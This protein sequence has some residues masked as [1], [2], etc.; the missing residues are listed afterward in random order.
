[1]SATRILILLL[2]ST[3]TGCSVIEKHVHL[4]PDKSTK[5]WQQSKNK[6]YRFKFSWKTI[7]YP[8]SRQVYHSCD[9]TSS[10]GIYFLQCPK[11][12]AIGPP[13]LPI[14]PRLRKKEVNG[15]AYEEL[16]V[17]LVIHTQVSLSIDTLLKGISFFFDDSATPTLPNELTIYDDRPPKYT[18]K[19]GY[20]CA[21]SNTN[22]TYIADLK[23]K[24]KPYELQ[25]VEIAFDSTFNA[26][27]NGEY[28]NLELNKKVR[29]RYYPIGYWPFE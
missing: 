18:K 10:V 9:S 3:C 20:F 17:R 14:V 15:Y 13:L 28:T 23:F 2:I 29:G 12:V 5:G 4:K 6:N 19:N 1:M 22:N 21:Q 25:H 16:E 7:H 24:I 27:I 26:L 11:V 8:W